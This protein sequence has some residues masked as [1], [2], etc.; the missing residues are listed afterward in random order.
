MTCTFCN[1]LPPSHLA[2]SHLQPRHARCP[3]T[4]AASSAEGCSGLR[5]TVKYSRRNEFPCHSGFP[6]KEASPM[7][8]PH[9]ASR[10]LSAMALLALL[11]GCGNDSTAPN[12]PFNPTGTSADVAAV[13]QSFESE[14][15][16]SYGGIAA[17]IS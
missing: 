17:E 9:Y 3:C 7:R 16:A 10:S 4:P 13:G 8:V 15:L 12:A 2:P 1:T 11:A 5:F 6:D 14:A